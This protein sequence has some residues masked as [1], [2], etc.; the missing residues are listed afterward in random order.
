[1]LDMSKVL[2][3]LKVI[4]ARDRE[5]VGLLEKDDELRNNWTVLRRVHNRI[6]KRCEW[7]EEAHDQLDRGKDG[8][9]P[10]RQE[11]RME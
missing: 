6:D 4:D 1:M 3:L 8:P 9:Q 5:K 10:H 2:P 11:V 7:N